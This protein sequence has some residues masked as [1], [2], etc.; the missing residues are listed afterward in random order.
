[1][2]KGSSPS[3][4]STLLLTILAIGFVVVPFLFWQGTWFGRR[5]KPDEIS[6]FL[7]DNEHPRKI[8]HALSQVVDK[9][10]SGEPG[11]ERWHSDIVAL[12]KNPTPQ[13]RMTAA[14]A[15]GHDDKS[16]AFHQSL[17]Q[18]LKD[19]E[20][21]VRRNAALALV[22]FRDS[23]GHQEILQ[24]LEPHVV[25]APKA[26]TLALQLQ[27]QQEIG[28]GTL[29]A[30]ITSDDGVTTEVRSPFPGK[31]DSVFARDG[32]KASPGD[33]IVSLAPGEEQV[34]EALRG[35]Y[36]IG[37]PA[38][39]PSVE[40]YERGGEETPDRIRQQAVLTARSI[41]TRAEQLST[42]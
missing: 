40:R 22:K 19:S 11:A 25:T 34:W 30:K 36:L 12:A 14:W 32:A 6:R 42:H 29:L 15:M 9:I 23:A 4:R 41:R 27:A 10:V 20:L 1:M 26:G 38:D 24:M 33:S 37:E 31:V 18:L 2:K 39:L 5:L 17:L 8:Q 3:A 7:A 13:V 21:M 16:E 28:T 35:L